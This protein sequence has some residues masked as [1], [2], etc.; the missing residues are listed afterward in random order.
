M[1][2]GGQLGTFDNAGVKDF[3]ST[4]AGYGV[5]A[6]NQ[7]LFFFGG[8]GAAPSAGARS[9]ALFTSNDPAQPL[10]PPQLA[11]NS[12]NSGILLTTPR[13]LLGSAVQSAFIFLIAGQTNTS[14]A[15]NSTELVI[16]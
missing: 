6:A 13:Y 9:A 15:S 1:Q 7:Q 11:A 16:W 12:W 5:C 14:A 2:A 8:L 3:T 4:A 10:A